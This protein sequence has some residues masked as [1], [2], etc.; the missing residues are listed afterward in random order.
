M[1]AK[2]NDAT[3][4]V[5]NKRPKDDV[6]DDSKSASP[7][8]VGKEMAK[9]MTGPVKIIGI[10]GS[11]RKASCNSGLLRVI[12]NA[13]KEG[14]LEGIQFEIV[15]YDELPM[16][17]QDLEGNDKKGT[18]DPQSAIDFRA[19][20]SAADAIVF[21]TAEYNYGIS[22]PLKNAID[23]GSRAGNAFKGKCAT[24]V[25]GGGGGKSFK[26][27]YELRQMAVFLQLQMITMP[28]VGINNWEQ[29]DG[30]SIFNFETGDLIDETLKGRVVAQAKVLR[31]FSRQTRMGRVAFELMSAK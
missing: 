27:Q 13:V 14:T 11:L 4:H 2:A 12:E 7:E 6:S 5:V 19:K 28:E 24:M 8:D 1:A 23:W 10:S 16:F 30:K 22:S 9:I 29:R 20:V 3:E 31:D 26:S 25:G 21:A 17:N 15:R 18:K